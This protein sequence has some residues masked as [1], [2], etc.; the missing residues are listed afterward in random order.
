MGFCLNLS[1]IIFPCSE[2]L[3][4]FEIWMPICALSNSNYWLG[5]LLSSF[6]LTAIVDVLLCVMW[7]FSLLYDPGLRSLLLCLGFLIVEI[8]VTFPLIDASISY[9]SP[10]PALRFRSWSRLKG[11]GV[12]TSQILL[13]LICQVLEI[14]GVGWT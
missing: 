9:S 12:Y 4:N 3:L 1:I 11:F 7:K 8:I 6:C 5:P 2:F 13:W 14:V 10:C